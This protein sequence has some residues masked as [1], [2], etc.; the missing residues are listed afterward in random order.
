MVVFYPRH[1]L[2]NGLVVDSSNAIMSNNQSDS[3]CY[4]FSKPA[5][6]SLADI[7]LQTE[8]FVPMQYCIQDNKL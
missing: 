4:Y 6:T 2:A 3:K 8:K 5:G 1:K 7:F